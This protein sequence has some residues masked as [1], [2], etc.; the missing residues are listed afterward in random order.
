MCSLNNELQVPPEEKRDTK[1]FIDNYQF[2]TC[3]CTGPKDNRISFCYECYKILPEELQDG[4]QGPLNDEEYQW[5]W[6][7][8]YEHLKE[9]GMVPSIKE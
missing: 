5:T 2:K 6:N 9:A 4:L 7:K 1:F 3:V 8:C